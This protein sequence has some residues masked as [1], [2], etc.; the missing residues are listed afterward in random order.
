MNRGEIT[1]TLALGCG[2]IPAVA[3]S[4]AVRADGH[5]KNI[6]VF[7]DRITWGWS[8]K[9]PIVLTVRRACRRRQMASDRWRGKSEQLD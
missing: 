2:L 9:K 4:D 1:S 6:M 8:P 5:V 7:G 3:A